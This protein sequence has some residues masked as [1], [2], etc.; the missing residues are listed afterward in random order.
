M[1]ATINKIYEW[2]IEAVF[3]RAG[4]AKEFL[5]IS[6][7]DLWKILKPAK[8]LTEKNFKAMFS[9]QQP[10]I[11]SAIWEIKYRGDILITEKISRLLYDY[12]LQEISEAETFQNFHKPL[13]IAIPVSRKSLSER[14]FNQTERLAKGLDKIDGGNNFIF[15]NESL[16]KVRDTERQS[17][18]HNRTERLK[19]LNNC[20]QVKNPELI[21]GKNIILLDDVITTGATMMEAKN[22]L[23]QAGAKKIICLAV[24]H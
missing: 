5:E 15:N 2:L 8:D 1:L 4:L 17:H 21:R 7:E 24:A 12:L 23:K 10:L 16:I 14:G 3:P 6:E 18:T 19:N 20:F 22:A 13:L 11:R 9:Y